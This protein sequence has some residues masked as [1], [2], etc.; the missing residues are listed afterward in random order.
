M[1][2]QAATLRLAILPR[3]GLLTDALLVAGGTVFVAL[4]AQVSIKLGFTPVPLTG[5]TFAVLVVGSVLGSTRG[6]LS[7]LLYLAVG[8]AGIPV[9][10]QHRHGWSVFTGATGGYIVGFVVAA[11][12]T[13]W[14]AERNWDKSFS[15]S[16]AAMLT[17]TVVI[18]ACGVT[19]L[20]HFL[21][22]SW[23]TT[24][25][26]GLYPFVPGDI[27]KVYLAAAVLPGAWRLVDRIRR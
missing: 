23:G 25:N 2:T 3:S 11:T 9:Y 22:V 26:D 6:A 7:L 5:Q 21:G 27:L 19:W 8:A 4:A 12:L 13:G 10:A 18:Y 14:L 20:H 16:I 1:Q 24:L 17:G 15:S